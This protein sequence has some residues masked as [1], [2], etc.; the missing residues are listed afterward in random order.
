MV[1]CL[2]M[3]CSISL[4]LASALPSACFCTLATKS[5]ERSSIGG[6]FGSMP[7]LMRCSLISAFTFLPASPKSIRIRKDKVQAQKELLEEDLEIR[8]LP[9]ILQ[10]SQGCLDYRYILGGS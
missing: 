3:A 2:R 10:H 1:Q 5:S 7:R 4:A 6:V 9:D 8:P